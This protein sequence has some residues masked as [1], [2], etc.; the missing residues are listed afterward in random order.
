MNS[1]AGETA[2]IDLH[3]HTV[4]EAELRLIEFLEAQPKTV[5]TVEVTH[6]YSHGT[7]LKRMVRNDFYHWRVKDKR[8]GLNAGVTL[9]ILK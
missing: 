9:L 3:G 4:D 5:H 1:K 7:A 8:V 6:G 2:A